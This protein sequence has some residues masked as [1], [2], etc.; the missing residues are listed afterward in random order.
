[1]VELLHKCKRGFFERGHKT[2][3]PAGSDNSSVFTR[4]AITK[5]APRSPL[6]SQPVTIFFFIP[7]FLFVNMGELLLTRGSLRSG[8]ATLDHF[9]A[10]PKTTPSFPC[11]QWVYF[12][13]SA[14]SVSLYRNLIPLCVGDLVCVC[15]GLGRGRQCVSEWEESHMLAV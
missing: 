3:G 14:L 5:T 13:F 8:W 2:S 7:L 15:C 1:M 12:S 6:L 9:R 4:G 10:H 11:N